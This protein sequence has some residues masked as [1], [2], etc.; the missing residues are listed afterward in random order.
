[1]NHWASTN[2]IDILNFLGNTRGHL[3]IFDPATSEHVSSRTIGDPITAL[4][5]AADSKMF[6]I[7]YVRLL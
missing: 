3:V 2:L 4:A 1:M 7:G 6:A 5:I